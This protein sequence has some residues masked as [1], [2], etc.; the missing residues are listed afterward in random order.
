MCSRSAAMHTVVPPALKCLAQTTFIAAP[1]AMH[2][3]LHRCHY[4]RASVGVLQ[5]ALHALH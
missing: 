4:V 1:P 2:T 5:A 3:T